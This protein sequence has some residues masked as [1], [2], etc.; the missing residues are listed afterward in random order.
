VDVA[1][2][3]VA[4]RM[5][6]GYRDAQLAFVSITEDPSS[7][8]PSRNQPLRRALFLIIYAPRRGILEVNIS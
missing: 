7:D 1:R 3:G 4:V 6:K 5:W 2:G 8:Q